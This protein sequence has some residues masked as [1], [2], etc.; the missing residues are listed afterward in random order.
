MKWFG[1]KAARETARPFLL[2][3]LPQGIAGA[4]AFG[5]ETPRSYEAQVREGYLGN[6]VAQRAV[7][8]V[9]EGVAGAV[10]YDTTEGSSG[11]PARGYPSTIPLARDGPPP[12]ASS[13]RN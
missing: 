2:R 7:K 4:S 8:L 12:R 11:S 3:G 1:R 10:I 13:G 9:A 6:P 5:G